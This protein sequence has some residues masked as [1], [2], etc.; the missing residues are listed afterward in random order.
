M[1]G[2]AQVSNQKSEAGVW[3]LADATGEE[4]AE[5]TDGLSG[6]V[7][8]LEDNLV[9][10]GAIRVHG[11]DIQE[12]VTSTRP[13]ICRVNWIGPK[14]PAMKKMG[15]LQGKSSLAEQWNGTACEFAATK[16]EEVTLA[17]IA[18][19]LLNS[20]GAHKPTQYKF[21]PGE[22]IPLADVKNKA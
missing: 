1:S 9:M 19:V 10:F 18:L 2:W 16:K 20:G 3:V 6:L 4:V 13:K 7:A 22:T 8:A 21:G 5:G 12:N 14:V 17:A 11:E 15:A